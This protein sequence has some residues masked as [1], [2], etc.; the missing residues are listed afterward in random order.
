MEALA[1]HGKDN[2]QST[3]NVIVE[4]AE[5]LDPV[6]RVAEW[7]QTD[8]GLEIR[9]EGPVTEKPVAFRLTLI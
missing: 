3:A 9:T 7:K 1:N 6:L 5:A 2:S 4:R 8:R